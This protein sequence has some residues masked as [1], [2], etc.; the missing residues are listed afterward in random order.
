MGAFDNLPLSAQPFARNGIPVTATK[1]YTLS[2]PPATH[3]RKATCSEVQCPA[4]L[5]GFRT[6]VDETS[7]LGQFQADY[8][9]KTSGRAFVEHRDEAGMTVF[10]FEAGQRCFASDNHQVPLEREPNYLVRGGDWRAST[11][12]IRRH[13]NGDDWVDDFGEHQEH[14]AD[15]H[16]RG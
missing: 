3:W 16:Q 4:Y 2:A 9:R 13:A 8:I 15:L 10:T 1:T 6:T 12:L 14:I 5:N 7:P 11:G